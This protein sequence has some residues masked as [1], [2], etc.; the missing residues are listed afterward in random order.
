M[1]R[2]KANGEGGVPS[3]GG[4]QGRAASVAMFFRKNIYIILMILCILAIAA[5]ITVAAVLGSQPEDM[6]DTPTMQ[7]PDDDKDEDAVTTPDDDEQPVINPDDDEEPVW[8]FAPCLPAT[9]A[10]VIKE[11]S[12][13]ELV[14][15]ATENKWKTHLGTDFAAAAGTDVVAVFDGE[16]T[17]VSSDSYYGGVVEITHGNG[18]VTTCKLLGDVCVAVGDE[19]SAGDKIGVVSSDFYFE[20]ADAPHVHMELAVNG[21]GEDITTYLKEG[22]K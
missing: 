4:K 16:V 14:F 22:D 13:T 1:K 18:Y 3:E 7:T 20:C 21:A 15:S 17:A 2:K 9:D 10:T 19:V 8:T 6:P 12:D 11:Y 5:M